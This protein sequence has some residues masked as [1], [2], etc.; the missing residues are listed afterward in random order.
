MTI[1]V[2]RLCKAVTLPLYFPCLQGRLPALRNQADSF[3][4]CLLQILIVSIYRVVN[5]YKMPDCLLAVPRDLE[6]FLLFN[7]LDINSPFNF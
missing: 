2:I 1:H 6:V 7:S 4:P 3:V 5:V